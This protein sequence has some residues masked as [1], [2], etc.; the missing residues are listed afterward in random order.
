MNAFTISVFRT[1]EAHKRL[2]SVCYEASAVPV[3]SFDEKYLENAI[4]HDFIRE[5]DN[6]KDARSKLVSLSPEMRAR[7]DSFFDLAVGEVRTAFH[8]MEELGLPLE[9]S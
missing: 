2:R 5:Q 7:L 1:V 4:E 3:L 8:N 6:P 9:T